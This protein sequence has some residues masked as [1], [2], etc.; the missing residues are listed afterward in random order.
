MFVI[1]Y[2]NNVI[3]GPM[4]WNA[5]RFKTVIE[6]DCEITVSLPSS[7]QGYYEIND[8]IKIYPVQTTPNPSYDSRTEF[9]NGPYYDFVDGVAISRMEVH[10]LDIVAAQNFVK[11]DA[12]HT[13]WKKQNSG[14]QYNINGTDYTF[15]TDLQTKSTFHQY[16]T[17][18]VDNL[19]WKV[20][21]DTWITLSKSDIKNIFVAIVN[22][23]QSAFDW[24]ADKLL[25]INDTNHEALSTLSLE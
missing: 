7:N 1:V 19:N 13:R 12:A 9:L 20:D 23:V 5:G 3:L 16:V 15:P 21:Q 11:A 8:D 22:H 4:I 6:E 10:Q 18:D 2:K 14:I 25:E 17:A 24:E